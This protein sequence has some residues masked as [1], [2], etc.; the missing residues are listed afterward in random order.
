MPDCT[1]CRIR[2]WKFW[3]PTLGNSQTVDYWARRRIVGILLK[4]CRRD[5]GA[6]SKNRL[7]EES[8]DYLAVARIAAQ[9]LE[10]DIPES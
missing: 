6:P 7:K 1:A 8:H 2:N 9:I 10:I 4:I 5:A 3:N